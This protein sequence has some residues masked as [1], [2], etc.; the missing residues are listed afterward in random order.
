MTVDVFGVGAG[1]W[2]TTGVGCGAGVAPIV[3]AAT[4]TTEIV[5]KTIVYIIFIAVVLLT[6]D[7]PS[8]PVARHLRTVCCANQCHSDIGL[9][10][11]FE[12]RV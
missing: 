8:K 9:F 12:R 11:I 1:V 7:L 3:H 6:F 4:A 2:T 5:P 10:L